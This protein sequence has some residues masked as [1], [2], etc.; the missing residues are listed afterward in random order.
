MKV[1]ANG[2]AKTY[3]VDFPR[4]D[5][6][7]NIRE[8]DYR[9][10]ANESPDMKNMW[11]RDGVL[12]CRDGQRYLSPDPELGRCRA[13]AERPF[14][15]WLICHVGTSLCAA[16]LS[17][18]QIGLMVLRDGVPEGRGTFFLYDD[19]LFYKNP[20]GYYRV[21]YY[22]SPY[23]PAPF[24]ARDMTRPEDDVSAADWPRICRGA[25]PTRVPFSAGWG[26]GAYTP[27]ILLNAD[28]STGAGTAYQPE[29]RL[30]PCMT[31]W[32]NAAEGVTAYQLPVR[33]LERLPESSCYCRITVDGERLTEYDDYTVDA[34]AGRV[35]FRTA[36]PVSDPA[37]NNTVRI[38]CCKSN[39]EALRSV[40]DCPC[41]I[42][43]GNGNSL[44]VVLSGGQAQSN[45]VFWN[46]NDSAGMH[47][48]YFPMGYYNLCGSAGEAVTGFA[49]QYDDLIVL[50]ERSVG[51]LEFQI[52]EVSDTGSGGELKRDAIAFDYRQINSK[53]GCDL[54]QTIQLIENNVVFCNT[55][56]GVHIILSSSAAFEN[57]ISCI[58][59]KV[60]G[61]SRGLLADV[62]A[63]PDTAVGVD[64]NEHYWF[65]ANGH[66]YV[67]DYNRTGFTDPSWYYFE[68]IRG[69]AWFQDDARNLFHLNAEGRITK[70]ERSFHDYGQAIEK[71]F[72]TPTLSF[73]RYDRRKDVT[74]L[75]IEIRSDTSTEV[76]IRYDTDRETRRDRTP[77]RNKT[78]RLAP[79]DL[80]RWNLTVSRY[81]EV[82]RRRPGCRRVRHFSVT[83]SNNNVYEDL[84]IVAVQIYYRFSG[85]ER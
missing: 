23:S 63:S 40:L 56:R 69:V 9:L 36:P 50:K 27:V 79:L 68:N 39:P 13:C 83:L 37:V 19:A 46:G 29:N 7:L 67:W 74:D 49:M 32:Y 80:G 10:D 31:V 75:L 43:A 58:S 71:S 66:A 38:T 48:G 24:L 57:N 45:A 25:C 11:W 84:A 47:P 82:A 64:D 53:I 61:G 18:A 4:L 62:R 15:G 51:K 6:G 1:N 54:P 5:G 14:H 20:G 65:S 73:G 41:A 21:D 30:S 3:V 55:K 81:A 70:L 59:E 42:T 16:D 72:T 44:C 26:K 60:N 28:P 2:F 52:V 77:I 34:A 17:A 22:E 85:K 12:Q 35:I 8:L 76:R 78:W 33:E